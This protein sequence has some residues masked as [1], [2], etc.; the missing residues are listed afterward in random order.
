MPESRERSFFSGGPRAGFS[1]WSDDGSVQ[2]SSNTSPLHPN[3]WIANYGNFS[4]SDADSEK[5]SSSVINDRVRNA[6]E[7]LVYNPCTHVKTIHSRCDYGFHA[8]V[9]APGK[10]HTVDGYV[11]AL[12]YRITVNTDAIPW[13]SLVSDVGSQ[14][15]NRLDTNSLLLV[16]L[17]EL[18]K[19][20]Q[21]VKNPFGLLK[22]NWREVARGLTAA[23]LA[24]KGASL[25]LENRYGWQ[26]MFSELK[27]FTKSYTKYQ[28]AAHQA[29][30][31]E[32]RWQRF[33]ARQRLPT[34]NQS[35]GYSTSEW[36]AIFMNPVSYKSKYG[37]T[38]P[39]R[40]YRSI[41]MSNGYLDA[42]VGCKYWI[43]AESKY[44]KIT[45]AIQALNLDTSGLLSTLWEIV[46][47]SFVVDWFVD[48]Q[49]MVAL[50][51]A[52]MA[53]NSAKCKGLGHTVKLVQPY[54]VRFLPDKTMWYNV[55]ATSPKPSSIE[56][57]RCECS[58]G[59][60]SEYTRTSGLPGMS[61]TDFLS[62]DL[63]SIQKADGIGLIIQ[64]LF[65]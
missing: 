44:S 57:I 15:R 35:Y 42:I 58:D 30:L 26:S 33:S 3:F 32:D 7:Q 62:T 9:P 31:G 24:V 46:P 10:S 53:L 54:K 61:L 47:Y 6:G 41:D 64:R 19:T 16:T 50:P 51:R 14:V 60:Y 34:S 45:R 2:R 28:I 20:V 49:G 21:M 52:L 1:S 17:K 36:E 43:L 18:G 59:I 63:T 48:F 38:G 29:G 22:T 55:Y 12:P 13:A 5:K 23:K 39:Y 56:N 65:S 8:T 37:L 25:W 27:G 4:L 11:T 40:G